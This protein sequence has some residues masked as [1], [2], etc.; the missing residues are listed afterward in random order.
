MEPEEFFLSPQGRLFLSFLS[1]PGSFKS[2]FIHFSFLLEIFLPSPLDVL[3]KHWKG[4]KKLNTLRILIILIFIFA[5][6][7]KNGFLIIIYLPISHLINCIKYIILWFSDQ[8]H[9]KVEQ[10]G[11]LKIGY[12]SWMKSTGSVVSIHYLSCLVRALLKRLNG[13]KVR[14]HVFPFEMSR[15]KLGVL[16]LNV[17]LILFSRKATDDSSCNI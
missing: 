9:K 5:S 14:F 2:L 16:A 11:Q 17:A 10:K 13:E 8:S 15:W 12:L 4:F 1:S 6:F 7:G 3:H